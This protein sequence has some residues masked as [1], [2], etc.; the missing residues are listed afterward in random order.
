[1]IIQVKLFAVARDLVGADQ[2]QVELSGTCTVETLKEAMVQLQPNLAPMI[3]FMRI[4]V[5]SQFATA[6]TQILADSEIAC[7]PPV[8]GG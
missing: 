8:S 6:D 7:I 3:D 2:L 5:D 1:M 4:A